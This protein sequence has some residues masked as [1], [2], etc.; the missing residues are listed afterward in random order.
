MEGRLAGNMPARASNLLAL[1][2]RARN[3]VLAKLAI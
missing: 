1:P 3:R 2:V